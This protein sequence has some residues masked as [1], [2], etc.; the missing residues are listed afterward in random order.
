MMQCR[1]IKDCNCPFSSIY[2]TH[3]IYVLAFHLNK[4]KTE[5]ESINF[6]AAYHNDKYYFY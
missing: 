2:S 6:V 1:V 5:D 3:K 4:L